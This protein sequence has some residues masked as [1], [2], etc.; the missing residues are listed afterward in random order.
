M[1]LKF[2]EGLKDTAVLEGQSVTLKVKVTK[3]G[4]KV[5]WYRNGK[6]RVLDSK[7]KN[8]EMVQKQ[9]F[10]HLTLHKVSVSDGIDISAT[11]ADDT[12]SCKLLIEG[13]VLEAF[14]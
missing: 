11:Y 7:N 1:P 3:K 6:E 13:I 10:Y 2:K 5:R 8:L 9:L 4:S 14:R 12:T